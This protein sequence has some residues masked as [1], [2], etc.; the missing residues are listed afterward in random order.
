MK[1]IGFHKPEEPNGYL[2]NWHLSD[3][4]VDGVKFTSMEQYMM[5]QKA[6]LFDDRELAQQILSTSNAGKIKALG[7][8]VR[9]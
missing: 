3:F 9:N 7:R 1:I 2:S 4:E 6:I 5:Y 8:A